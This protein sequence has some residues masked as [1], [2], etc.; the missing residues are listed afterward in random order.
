MCSKLSII[1]LAKYCTFD[2][3]TPAID[4]LPVFNKWKKNTLAPE[5]WYF[6][7]IFAKNIKNPS[8]RI[9]SNFLIST[10]AC[11]YSSQLSST[12][13]D[14]CSTRWNWT[15]RFAWWYAANYFFQN[16]VFQVLLSINLSSLG[17]AR[18][19]FL[20]FLSIGRR[21]RG[22]LKRLRRFGRREL[23]GCC[24]KVVFWDVGFRVKS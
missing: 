17:F 8:F 20:C 16:P 2:S 18:S 3:F 7:V 4:I 5:I 22:C 9:F 1:P 14:F 10:N 24:R 23:V 11:K 21:V 12:H 6:Y 19:W 15:Y 13:T